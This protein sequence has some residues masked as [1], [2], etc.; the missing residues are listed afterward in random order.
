MATKA[1]ALRIVGLK[2]AKGKSNAY[3]FGLCCMGGLL[4]N[5]FTF[6]RKSGAILPPSFTSKGKRVPLVKGHGVHWKRVQAMLQKKL[7]EE[8]FNK[9]DDEITSSDNGD[10]NGD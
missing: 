9:D 7:E 8:G 3:S 5:G 2:E 1:K 4:V 10:G 6:F